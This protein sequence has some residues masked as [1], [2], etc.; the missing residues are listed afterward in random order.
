MSS[1][2]LGILLRRYLEESVE[3]RE[4]EVSII[5]RDPILI[6][7]LAGR[8]RGMAMGLQRATEKKFADL[9]AQT[10]AIATSQVQISL[11]YITATLETTSLETLAA[12][13][14]IVLVGLKEDRRQYEE[15]EER[16]R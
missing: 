9:I 10:R 4:V 3:P 6:P 14:D 16:R 15:A 1:P 7:M 13:P 2:N 11:G 12:H 8:S 5:F